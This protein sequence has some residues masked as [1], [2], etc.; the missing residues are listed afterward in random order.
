MFTRMSNKRR[1][2]AIMSEA[3][4]QARL[5]DPFAATT[6]AAAT[7]SAFHFDDNGDF[8]D[9]AVFNAAAAAQYTVSRDD[10]N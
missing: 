2:P 1:A 9:D 7:T 5:D 10:F 8:G 6:P 3:Q 4:K